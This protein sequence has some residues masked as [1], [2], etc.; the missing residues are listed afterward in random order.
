MDLWLASL[1][2]S[3]RFIPLLET[4]GVLLTQMT[5]FPCKVFFLHSLSTEEMGNMQYLFSS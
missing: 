3:Y 4:L 1:E 2:S 5:M